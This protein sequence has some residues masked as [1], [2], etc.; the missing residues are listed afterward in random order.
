MPK[1]S[2]QQ[3]KSIDADNIKQLTHQDEFSTIDFS[4]RKRFYVYFIIYYV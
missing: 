3:F 2:D 4:H 1:L